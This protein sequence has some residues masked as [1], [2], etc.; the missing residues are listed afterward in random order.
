MNRKACEIKTPHHHHQWTER[1]NTVSADR[2]GHGS[3]CPKRC[4]LH[5]RIHHGKEDVRG[6]FNELMNRFAA[7]AQTHHAVAE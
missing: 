4:Q 2:E 1:R 3:A 6:S 5:E 7:R